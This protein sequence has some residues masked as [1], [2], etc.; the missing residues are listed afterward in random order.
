MHMEVQEKIKKRNRCNFLFYEQKISIIEISQLLKIKI[1]E[2]ERIVY[3]N[4]PDF[5]NKYD[6]LKIENLYKKGHS[7]DVIAKIQ[8]TDILTILYLLRC[9]ARS[10]NFQIRWHSKTTNKWK[11]IKK[12]IETVDEVER[13]RSRILTGGQKADILIDFKLKKRF[14]P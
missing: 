11:R 5:T 13:N 7:L 9:I 12:L 1:E 2:I 4:I 14:V 3:Q 6:I 10:Y 8:G